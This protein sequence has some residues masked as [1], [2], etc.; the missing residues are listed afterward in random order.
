MEYLSADA[1]FLSRLA[2]DDI[3]RRCMVFAELSTHGFAVLEDGT[4]RCA[5]YHPM[6][7]AAVFL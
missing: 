4:R 3:V 5:G 6:A 1:A 7:L 2:K